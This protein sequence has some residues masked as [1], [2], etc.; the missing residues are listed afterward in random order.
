MDFFPLTLLLFAS[1][2]VFSFL[3]T[4][5]FHE[6]GHGISALLMT[7]QPVTIYIGSYGDKNNSLKIKL[8]YLEIWIK[9]NPFLWKIGICIFSLDQLSINKRIFI[10]LSGP[11]ASILIA[12]V[13]SYFAFAYDLHG[14][15]KLL[16]VIFFFLS[17]FDLI[18]NLIPYSKP[19]RVINGI[20]VYN[21]GQQLKK[22]FFHKKF[23][24]EINRGTELFNNQHF[25]EAAV[26]FNELL[27]KRFKDENIYRMAIN[28]NIRSD[29]YIVAKEQ[30]DE[31]ITYEYLNS[32]DF[33]NAGFIY[34]KLDHYEKA[35]DFFD[36]SLT[37][38]PNNKYALNNK[39]FT[40]NLL[41]NFEE[42]LLCF[43][44]A[45][46]IDGSFAYSYSNRGLAK[47]KTGKLEDGLEDINH[48]IFLDANNSYNYRNLGIYY[49]EKNEYG[50]ALEFYKK[51]KELD[52]TTHIIDELI[53]QAENKI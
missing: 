27:N 44:K 5:I 45:I 9:Y 46:E 21:D 24:V 20:V 38:N 22:L 16:F 8:S 41:N 34:L 10:T 40:L 37:L 25:S 12:I 17:I 18:I 39:G 6:L 48:S 3:T 26:C 52:G 15:L 30:T 50:K 13:A 53:T 28:S 23:Q 32:D 47:I 36:K 19:T 33:F 49:F 11:F 2:V 42:A 1:L 51:A 4:T 43:D 29:N 31:L 14:F 7:K 35:I